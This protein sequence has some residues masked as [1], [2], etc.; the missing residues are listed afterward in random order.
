MFFLTD[1]IEFPPVSATSPEGIIAFGGDLSVERLIY[2]YKS[3]I[4]PWFDDDS[5][6]IWWAPD[7]RMVLFPENLNIS[8]SMNQL[9]KS[10]RFEVT[11]NQNFADVIKNCS[12]V[13]RNGQNSS[14]I[15][16]EM[17][18][19]YIKLHDMGLAQSVEVWECNTL[20]G[21]LYGIDLGHVFCGESMFSKVS[22]ASKFALIKLVQKLQKLN[23]ELIDCQVYT[24][25]LESLGAEEIPREE[26]LRILKKD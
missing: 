7:P 17:I 12:E 10:N 6:I 9:L 14:W 11:F 21:G 13:K 26:F 8:K 19:A 2:A 5:L 16:D 25:H 24:R 1:K 3:G 20:V 23:Y 22:N 18:N 15:T 4:F